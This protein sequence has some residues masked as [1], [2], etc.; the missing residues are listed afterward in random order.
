M[1]LAAPTDILM[2]VGPETTETFAEEDEEEWQTLPARPLL[3]FLSAE[4][5]PVL[6][7]RIIFRKEE[8]GNRLWGLGAER[9]E[10]ET[11]FQRVMESDE[12]LEA[13]DVY[14][15]MQE[16]ANHAGDLLESEGLRTGQTVLWSQVP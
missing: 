9:E 12:P 10:D 2:L 4:S 11:L 16:L 13:P 3:F 14:F 6:A 7:I 5:E 1:I 8:D 15:M